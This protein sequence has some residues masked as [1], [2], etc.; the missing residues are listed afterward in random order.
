MGEAFR[1]WGLDA[2]A[3]VRLANALTREQ[4]HSPLSK[5]RLAYWM[6]DPQARRGRDREALCR[7]ASFDK[8]VRP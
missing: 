7:G 3:A 5:H 1:N 6:A 8:E 4:A 2:L